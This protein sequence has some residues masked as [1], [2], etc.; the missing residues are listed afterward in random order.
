M[1]SKAYEKIRDYY[2][3]KVA[4]RSQVP[5]INHINEGL[6]VLKMLS[7]STWT[8][9][10][11]CL[12]PIVQNDADLRRNFVSLMST[13]WDP[14]TIMYVME[15]RNVANR[16]LLGGT[17]TTSPIEPVNAMLIA[18]KCQ[19]RKDFRLYHKNSHPK[20]TQL[21]AYFTAWL[22]ELGVTEGFYENAV[23]AMQRGEY[24]YEIYTSGP[25]LRP[26]KRKQRGGKTVLPNS[27]ESTTQT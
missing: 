5:L 22:K 18:D 27:Q 21:E 26:Q 8:K 19:N 3:V 7:A 23:K 1:M 13:E 9:D 24:T 16:G 15:Y 14:R 10:A 6:T 2:G 20:S 12:H 25:D 11:F 4:E 17:I